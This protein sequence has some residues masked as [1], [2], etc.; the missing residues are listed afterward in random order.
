MIHALPGMGAD[1]R[2]YSTVWSELPGFQAHDWP[3]I[4][5]PASLSTVAQAVCQ[6]GPIQDGDVLIG[7]SLGGM[8]ACE[9]AKLRRIPRLYLVS[10]AVD[11]SEVNPLLALLSPLARFAPIEWA[12]LS[13]GRVPGELAQMFARSDAAFVRTMCQAIFDW[14]GLGAT[15]TRVIRLH[16]RRDL[17]I[18]PPPQPDL[19]LDA[20][21]LMAMTHAAECVEF[22]RGT[23]ESK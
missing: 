20:G 8:I 21:H 15:T 12:Q 13:A 18:P 23:L 4:V 6:S 19:L 1:R 14:D 3:Q 9:I 7:A 11:R 16:G 10:S 22:I 5:R 17:V 2:M